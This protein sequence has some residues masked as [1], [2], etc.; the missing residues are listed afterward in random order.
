MFISF[1][2]ISWTLVSLVQHFFMGP[3]FTFSNAL[4]F[5]EKSEEKRA[6]RYF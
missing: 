4:A 3:L 2:L 5:F 1:V 6:C